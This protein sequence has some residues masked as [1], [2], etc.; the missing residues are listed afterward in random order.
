[1][2]VAPALTFV[3]TPLTGVALF[4]WATGPLRSSFGDVLVIVCMIAGLAAIRVG[5]ARARLVGV[6]VFAVAVECFQGLC[7]ISPDA[8]WWLLITLGSTFDPWDFAAYATGL[9]VAAGCERAWR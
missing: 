8:P 6:G 9:L 7:L 3:V 4:R 2:A 5:S 1:V